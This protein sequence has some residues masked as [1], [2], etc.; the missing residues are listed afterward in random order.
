[1]LTCQRHA[2]S[3]PDD[4]HYLNCGYMSP[5][6]R[7]V[8]A[9]GIDGIARKRV[10]S[11]ISAADFF[12]GADQVRALFAKLIN[13]A[14]P[15]RIAVVPSV[16]YGLAVAARNLKV[17]A[18]QAVVTMAEQ[19]P[20]NVHVWRRLCRETGAELRSVSA[21]PPAAGRGREWNTRLLEAID[22]RTAIVAIAHVHWAEGTRYDMEA[23]ARR[24]RDVGA[25]LVV[26]GT[27]SIGA[28]PFDVE[29]WQPDVVVCAAYKW[30]MG[31]YSY[32]VAY[33]NER[34]DHGVPLEEGWITRAGSEDFQGLVHYSDDYQPAAIRFD[35]GQRSNFALTPMVVA[36]LELVWS[37]QPARIQAY[38][39]SL[40][41]A[42]VAEA[43]GL[44]YFIEDD[45]SRG[46]HLFGIRIPDGIEPARV[47]TVLAEHRVSVSLR[48]QAI[49]VS[50]H[51]YNTDGDIDALAR[52]LRTLVA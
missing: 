3:L 4:E 7:A 20:S 35:V 26:D 9:A 2:F 6:P 36:G 1:M 13:V 28:L 52:V 47:S 16:S 15:Q 33:F 17:A 24:A 44:G 50:P 14:D 12:R 46:A 19:F 37:W 51:V 40:T 31:P 32:A 41:T 39:A 49:R 42:L 10:P 21:P 29:R 25:A 30:L 48:G 22:E 34:F 38:C 5:L 18:G 45:D 8:E 43:R 23:V 11:R 27:Q